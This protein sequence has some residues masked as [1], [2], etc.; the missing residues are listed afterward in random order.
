[1][2]PAV[3]GMAVTSESIY[4]KTAFAVC[5]AVVLAGC[6]FFGGGRTDPATSGP[7]A[8][9][10]TSK[11]ATTST[12][13]VISPDRANSLIVPKKDVAE[14]LGSTLDYEG[15]SSN[16]GSST[17]DGKE[18]CRALMVPL[19]VDLGD[20]WTTYRDVWY[21]ESKEEFAHS[22]TQRVLLYSSKD[23]AQDAYSKE[24]PADVGNCSGEELKADTA[25]W[26]ASV[27][28][29]SEGRAQWVLDEIIDGRPSGWRCML[30][31][32]IINNLLLSANVCQ[33][34]NGGPAV[35]AIMDRMVAAS[36]P[37]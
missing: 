10:G 5:S 15:K 12:V 29:V 16:P 19:T 30:E 33:L 1:M 37:K 8:V 31:A 35:K 34:G 28:E 9:S 2:D 14:L 26:R 22:V 24:F 6:S 25:T 20:K 17:I 4:L 11:T 7:S 3:K 36:K 23:D 27:R 13:D 32:R 18:S 21:R